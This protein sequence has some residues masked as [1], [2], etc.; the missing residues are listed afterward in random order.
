MRIVSGSM[1]HFAAGDALVCRKRNP[2]NYHMKTGFGKQNSD[3]AS[4]ACS[5]PR[6]GGNEN[7]NVFKSLPTSHRSRSRVGRER[8]SQCFQRLP[9]PAS[10]SF[11]NAAG[12]PASRFPPG[13]KFRRE[14]ESQCFQIVID[15]A[16]FP[17]PSWTGTKKSMISKVTASHTHTCMYVCV[18]M[19]THTHT[20]G[21]GA[22]GS[23]RRQS[24]SPPGRHHLHP[25]T[26][27]SGGLSPRRP[28]PVHAGCPC[29]VYRS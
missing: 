5:V 12:I 7:V 18:C 27:H 3:F 14:R 26:P 24:A 15:R 25:S 23:A 20:H 6:R 17:F 22:L 2:L 19:G 10:A 16:P 11:P 1:P 28:N 21:V 9:P 13:S 4:S 8:K 29:P